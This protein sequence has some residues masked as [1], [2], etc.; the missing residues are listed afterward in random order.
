M[1][2]GVL[3]GDVA[4]LIN[5]SDDGDEDMSLVGTVLSFVALVWLEIVELIPGRRRKW[6][7]SAS[8]KGRVIARR[9][10]DVRREAQD[11]RDR[12]AATATATA[13]SDSDWQ[14][15]IDAA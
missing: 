1:P 5:P 3:V 2:N 7:L 14:A 6:V 4:L 12:I 9:M 8:R 13:T 11:A 15:L 10:F